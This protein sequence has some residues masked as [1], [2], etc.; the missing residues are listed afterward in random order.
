MNLKPINP[1]VFISIILSH[2]TTANHNILPS[3][4]FILYPILKYCCRV[5]ALYFLPNKSLSHWWFPVHLNS[6]YCAFGVPSPATNQTNPFVKDIDYPFLSELAA[7][8]LRQ[9]V[10]MNSMEMEVKFILSSCSCFF[11]ALSLILF[12]TFSCC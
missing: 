8:K 7:R 9:I 5:T 1:K 12:K 6:F 4:T 2:L 10:W 11:F 3:P